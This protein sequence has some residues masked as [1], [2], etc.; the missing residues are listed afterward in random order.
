MANLQDLVVAQDGSGQATFNGGAT[1]TTQNVTIGADSG[2]SGS[3]SV[4]DSGTTLSAISLSIAPAGSGQMSAS[5]GASVSPRSSI[6]IGGA[7]R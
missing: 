1:A 7:G 2:A 3:V 5:D 6:T 4:A